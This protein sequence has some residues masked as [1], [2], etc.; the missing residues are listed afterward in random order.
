MQICHAQPH[1]VPPMKLVV[2]DD[3]PSPGGHHSRN[4]LSSWL[5]E[6]RNLA[7][8]ASTR[9]SM[10]MSRKRHT[11]TPLKISAPSDFRR[12]QSFQHPHVA[13]K[14]QPLELSIHRSGN[15]L[16]D[17]PSFESFQM[18]EDHQRPS[19]TFPPRALSSSNIRARRCQSTATVFSISRKPV[20]SGRRHSLGNLEAMIEPRQPAHIASALIPHFSVIAPVDIL[21]PEA[22]VSV[23]P[24]VHGRSNS[25]TTKSMLETATLVGSKCAESSQAEEVEPQTPVARKSLREEEEEVTVGQLSDGLPSPKASPSSASSHTLPS[26]ISSLRRPS[27]TPSDNG[28]KIASMP[29]P[30]L[31][32]QWLFPLK[33]E[34]KPLSASDTASSWERA[35]SL[36]GTTV[37]STVTT[38][39]GGAQTR[40][41]NSSVSST[42]TG[43]SIPRGSLQRPSLG[44]DKDIECGVYRPTIYEAQQ[45]HR[46]YPSSHQNDHARFQKA[47]IG[48][49][50]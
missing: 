32:S 18:N 40:K 29:L 10:G 15:R 49:A 11:T 13:T 36:S 34:P 31:M 27:L 8:R 16:S 19:L 3:L 39:T 6:G 2:Y 7:S 44:T 48:I 50:F 43:A 30:T 24:T 41:P 25:D 35:R 37:A 23:P 38:I 14:Y 26:R 33:T 1:L 22:S 5:E 12:V 46:V 47:S 21:L 17:L 42:F 4:S 9:A 20:G 28:K 45:Q